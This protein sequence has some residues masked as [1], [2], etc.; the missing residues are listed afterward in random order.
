M[1]K[2]PMGGVGFVFL[3]LMVAAS[4]CA[5]LQ[6]YSSG[7]TGCGPDEIVISNEEHGLGVATW[8]AEC[9]G[10]KYFCSALSGG[11]YATPQVSCRDEANP[12]APGVPESPA[13]CVSD[14]QCKG[15]RVCEGGR[16]VEPGSSRGSLPVP[17]VD[18]RTASPT[19]PSRAPLKSKSSAK[20][21][22]EDQMNDMRSAH[23]SESAILSACDSAAGTNK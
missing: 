15:N 12:R 22:S 18:S 6:Q 11:R 7:Q 9:R 2:S 3:I 13:G 21:C 20:L 14:N 10:Q 1:A 19:P 4:A 23:V 5:T 8:I 17:G 16:C